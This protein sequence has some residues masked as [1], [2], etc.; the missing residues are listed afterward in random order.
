MNDIELKVFKGVFMGFD[1]AKTAMRF[2]KTGCMAVTDS[3]KWQL[4]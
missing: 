1:I 2:L 4:I 3:R